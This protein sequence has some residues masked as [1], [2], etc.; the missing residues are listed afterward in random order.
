MTNIFLLHNFGVQ[1]IFL[2]L[3]RKCS[4]GKNGIAKY[5]LERKTRTIYHETIG[6]T[7][8]VKVDFN[9]VIFR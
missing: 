7:F 4:G 6:G 3:K 1:I 2:K 8:F 9:C 5:K